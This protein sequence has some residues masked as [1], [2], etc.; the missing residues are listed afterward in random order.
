MK[1]RPHQI[2]AKIKFEKKAESKD[3]MAKIVAGCLGKTVKKLMYSQMIESKLV[4]GKKGAQAA[5]SI[6]YGYASLRLAMKNLTKTNL[7]KREQTFLLR[8]VSSTLPTMEMVYSWKGVSANR[9]GYEFLRSAVVTEC[10]LC[11]GTKAMDTQDHWVACK[12]LENKWKEETNH[13]WKNMA[14]QLPKEVDLMAVYENNEINYVEKCGLIKK[15]T[16]MDLI[17]ID[18][19]DLTPWNMTLIRKTMLKV[20]T[21]VWNYKQNLLST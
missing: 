10:P 14:G 4:A 3:E 1:E 17:E 21:K 7:T 12:S 2:K 13:H 20:A 16:L 9:D 19:K 18:E 15:K 8:L 11:A 6:N 5:V